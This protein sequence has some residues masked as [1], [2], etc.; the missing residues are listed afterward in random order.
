MG[1][2][3]PDPTLGD[4]DHVHTTQ[5]QRPGVANQAW[6]S[7]QEEMLGEGRVPRVAACPQC[8]QFLGDQTEKGLEAV[9][10]QGDPD[11]GTSDSGGPDRVGLA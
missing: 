6:E 11:K 5:L 9:R 4:K 8:P 7:G 2:C 3:V 10:T 1:P